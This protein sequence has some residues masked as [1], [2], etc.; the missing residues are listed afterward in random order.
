MNTR[1]LLAALIGGLAFFFIG[2]L[3]WGI[4]LM[5]TMQS[6]SNPVAGCE[7]E[8]PV[9]WSLAL[10]NILSALLYAVIYERWA[11]IHTFRGGFLAGLLLSGILAL[12][13]DLSM[14]SFMSSWTLPVVALDWAANILVGGIVGG[15]IGWALGYKRV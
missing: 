6:L 10:A 1:I 3:V 9:M 15:I 4:L 7:R 5:D 11:R 2:W 8:M 13:I 12:S 14:F